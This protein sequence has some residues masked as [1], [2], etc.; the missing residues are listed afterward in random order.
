MGSAISA[1][2]NAIQKVGLSIIDVG[3][4]AI[5]HRTALDDYPPRPQVEGDR[6]GG[7]MSYLVDADEGCISDIELPQAPGSVER[8]EM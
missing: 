5:T 2:R 1:R 6:G 7:S 3:A 8:L 4:T